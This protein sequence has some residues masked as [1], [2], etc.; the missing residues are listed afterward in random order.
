MAQIGDLANDPGFQQLNIELVSLATDTLPILQT[1]GEE[2][3]V[4]T[5]LL[6]D[7]D[8]AVSEAYGV[9]RWATASGEPSHTFVL[10]GADGKVKWIQDYGAKEN[11]GRMYVPIDELVGELGKHI[12]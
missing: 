3:N 9:L 2:Y 11:G 5:W 10:V 1:V 7:E 4:T 6:S 8:K 12:D